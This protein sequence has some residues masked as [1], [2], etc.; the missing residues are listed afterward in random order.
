MPSVSGALTSKSK[1]ILVIVMTSSTV[2]PQAYCR[3]EDCIWAYP[4]SATRYMPTPLSLSAG[5][6]IPH[7][8]TFQ[9][10]AG[11]VI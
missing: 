1:S 6:L 7:I 10:T 2:K 4:L 5:P 8:P 11:V 9:P 3:N